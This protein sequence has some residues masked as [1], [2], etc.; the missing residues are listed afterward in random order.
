MIRVNLEFPNAV[1]QY[2]GM[3]GQSSKS[4]SERMASLP[5]F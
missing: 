2:S 3:G 4:R 5:S 1:G